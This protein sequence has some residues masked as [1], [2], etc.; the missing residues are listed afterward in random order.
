MLD[1]QNILSQTD[2]IR[3]YYQQGTATWQTWRKPRNCSYVWIMCIGGGASGGGGRIGSTTAT[4]GGGS[5]AVTKAI[6]PAVFLPDLLYVQPGPGGARSST[7]GI[8]TVGNRSFVSAAPLS[9]STANLACASGLNAAGISGAGES[10][11]TPASAF[12]LNLSDF[13]STAGV[14]GTTT[15]NLSPLAS[16]IV[17]PGTVAPTGVSAGGSFN[18]L[19]LGTLTTQAVPGGAVGG[20]NGANGYWSWKPMYGIGGAA[21][22][23]NAAGT[24]GNGGDAIGY[25]CGGGA[26][27]NG[28]VAGGLG[29]RGGDG[30]VIIATF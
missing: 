26:G 2:N 27:G 8:C 12:Y 29:G 20:G 4:A 13:I 6:Y 19:D 21:G 16:S 5:G 7:A 25:G 30:L 3:I 11:L 17:A 24:G 10:A 15:G 22:G 23:Y 28:S 1:I 18:V 14:A 9:T